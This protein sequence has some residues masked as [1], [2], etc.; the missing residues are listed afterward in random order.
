MKS[1]KMVLALVLVS[2]MALGVA[3]A[4]SS[5][6]ADEVKKAPQQYRVGDSNDLQAD[7]MQVDQNKSWQDKSDL[8]K[9]Q[10]HIQAKRLLKYER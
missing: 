7:E 8:M 2:N 1:L 5:L 9:H 4:Q 6:R 10:R 3:F